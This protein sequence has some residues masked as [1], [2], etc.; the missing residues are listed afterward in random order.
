MLVSNTEAT[1]HRLRRM[2]YDEIVYLSVEDMI[3]LSEASRD[4]FRTEGNPH[5]ADAME[6]LTF[7]LSMLT[8][9]EV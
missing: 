6:R 8:L 2:M 9:V 5:A 1:N 7:V 3:H 4:R